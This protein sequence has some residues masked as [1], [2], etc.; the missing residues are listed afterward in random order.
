MAG[1]KRKD[2][3][4]TNKVK[5]AKKIKKNE[6]A[7]NEEILEAN[8][9]EILNASPNLLSK[10]R[11]KK[12]NSN[13]NANNT[14]T[15]TIPS[16]QPAV[17]TESAFK[18][19]SK[20]NKTNSQH[21]KLKYAGSYYTNILNELVENSYNNQFEKK[22][23]SFNNEEIQYSP[24]NHFFEQKTQYDLDRSSIEHITSI[25]I[26]CGTVL[27]YQIGILIF[28]FLIFEFFFQ[29]FSK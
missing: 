27:K 18:E 13:A 23:F 20:A 28:F 6:Q 26:A 22:I 25:C 16:V 10:G 11:T 14:Q 3:E 24:I 7:N 17:W 29:N 12:H 4:E 9:H 21:P 2:S 8:P 15:Q 1:K 5:K 19:N